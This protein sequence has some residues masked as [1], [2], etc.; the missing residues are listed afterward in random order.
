MSTQ[1][2]G[3]KCVFG[4]PKV[5]KPIVIDVWFGAVSKTRLR[6]RNDKFGTLFIKSDKGVFRVVLEDMGSHWYAGPRMR[7]GWNLRWMGI[8]E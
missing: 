7:Q 4:V 8:A 2:Y 1:N 3:I 5:T 6:L